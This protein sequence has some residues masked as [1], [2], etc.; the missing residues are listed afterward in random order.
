MDRTRLLKSNKI[1]P[2]KSRTAP[3]GLVSRS[4]HV[5]FFTVPLAGQERK[6]LRGVVMPQALE[7]YRCRGCEWNHLCCLIFPILAFPVLPVPLPCGLLCI[8]CPSWCHHAYSHH[9][10][11]DWYH[12]HVYPSQIFLHLCFCVGLY[13]VMLCRLHCN[14]LIH[15]QSYVLNIF[16]H[17]YSASSSI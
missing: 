8:K 14:V 5:W 15:L 13:I 10:R 9:P 16:F 6:T 3:F 1:N 17:H 2:N 11:E 4:L 7:S 12:L